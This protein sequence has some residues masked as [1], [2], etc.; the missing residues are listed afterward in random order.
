M[1]LHAYERFSHLK[2]DASPHFSLLHFK[3]SQRIIFFLLEYIIVS[4]LMRDVSLSILT[5]LN[6]ASTVFHWKVHVSTI[7]EKTDQTEHLRK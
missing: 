5:G 6:I 2:L 3:H 1:M 4:L 7:S